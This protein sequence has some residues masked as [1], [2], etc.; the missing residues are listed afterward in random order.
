MSPS[1]AMRRVGRSAGRRF[2]GRRRAF[3]LLEVVIALGILVV[4]LVVLVEAQ[5]TAVFMTTEAERIIVANMLAREKMA[6]VQMLVELEGFGEQDIEE[7]GDF[8]NFE[9][10]G[11]ELEFEDRF[12]GFRWAYTVRKIELGLMGDLAGMA[13]DLA[14]SGYWGEEQGEQADTTA[15]PGLD[16]MGISPDMIT[17]MLGAYIREVRVVVWWGEN[18]DEADQVAIVSH[19]INPSGMVTSSEEGDQ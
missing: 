16:Q 18:E 1:A 12:E 6:E 13:G 8:D 19:V 7:E 4:S 10:E 11:L 14:G 17:E 9:P 3:T 2:G 15:T 5:A